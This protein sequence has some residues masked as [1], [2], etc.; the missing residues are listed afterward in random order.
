[1]I[2][3]CQNLVLLASAI[4]ATGCGAT[5][6]TSVNAHSRFSGPSP[7]SA[8]NAV[9][10][11][12]RAGEWN[13]L[14]GLLKANPVAKGRVE[15]WRRPEGPPT[16]ADKPQVEQIPETMLAYPGKYLVSYEIPNE[17]R[18]YK[19]EVVVERD[20]DEYRAIDFWGLGW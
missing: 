6:V 12:I 18:V 7:E 8:A 1:M 19:L 9:L 17:P 20:G 3:F 16:L 14:H 11:A 10:S 5:P 13:D 15:P 4:V 2:K